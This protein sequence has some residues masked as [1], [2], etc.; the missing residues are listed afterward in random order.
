MLRNIPMD[1]EI[2]RKWLQ[3]GYVEDG[4]RYPTEKGTP[5]GGIISPTLAN[6]TLDGLEQVIGNAVPRHNRVNFIRYADDFI[7]TGKSK[8]LLV[9]AVKPAVEAF[10]SERGLALSSEKTVVTGIHDGF[11][12]LGQTFRKH[13]RV[14]HI[15][16]AQRGVHALL[17]KIGELLRRSL[18]TPIEGLIKKLNA[19]L[20]G[21]ALY[22]RHVCASAAFG[23]VDTYVYE[24]LWRFL[25]RRHPNKRKGWLIR[26]YWTDPRRPHVLTVRS[27]YKT[28]TFILSVL[29]VTSIGI[30]RHIKIRAE[31]NPYDP[32]YTEYFRQRRRPGARLMSG[33][34]ARAVRAKAAA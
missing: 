29:R 11:T 16:P 24:Q 33:L 25:Q 7:I 34:S 28:K 26:K 18:S 10:L 15:A 13:G 4:R 32:A 30:K 2:L 20:R 27:K 31:A 9:E 17:R 22:H 3:A 23:R 12:F 6:M 8:Q 5:Q 14:L 19:M 21:W 1:K